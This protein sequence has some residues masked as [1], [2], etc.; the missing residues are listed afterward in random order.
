M[1]RIFSLLFSFL[2]ISISFAQNKTSQE[3]LIQ[4]QL[5]AYNSRNIDDFMKFYS[6]DIELYKFPDKL[7]SKGKETMKKEYEDMFKRIP[8]LNCE[9]LNR[10]I[11]GNF[12][13]DQEK[14]TGNSI[15]EPLVATVIYE[16]KEN[17]IIK[18]WLLQ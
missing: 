4:K 7:L 6:D 8:D 17:K 5:D 14:I 18:V 13:I 10:T 11:Q 12:V 16:V 15:R 3:L 1:K 2:C 9:I